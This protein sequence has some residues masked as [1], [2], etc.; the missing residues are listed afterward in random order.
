MSE[1]A[2]SLG[3]FQ[4]KCLFSANSLCAMKSVGRAGPVPRMARQLLDAIRQGKCSGCLRVPPVRTPLIGFSRVSKSKQTSLQDKH[5][6]PRRSSWHRR[7][8]FAFLL[9][10]KVYQAWP[11]DSLCY[12]HSVTRVHCPARCACA[13]HG[14]SST[15]AGAVAGGGGVCRLCLR[16]SIAQVCG[17][18][19]PGLVCV[20][21]PLCQ[22]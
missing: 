15:P 8:K 18:G 21:F 6:P 14:V 4:R 13:C 3:P 9:F 16:A 11:K 1:K 22:K 7:P 10:S 12:G 19:K 2:F 20:C 17:V 5:A